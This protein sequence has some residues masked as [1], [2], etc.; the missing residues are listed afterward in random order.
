[1]EKFIERDFVK[2]NKIDYDRIE[3]IFKN[4]DYLLSIWADHCGID[5]SDDRCVYGW[6]DKFEYFYHGY[7]LSK[8][9]DKIFLVVQR[10]ERDEREP[11]FAY[12]K[13]FLDYK[14]AIKYINNIKEIRNV[15]YDIEEIEI[16]DEPRKA[17]QS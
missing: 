2:G 9:Q 7:M 10:D 1:M 16:G 5:K 15:Y 12:L 8:N 6:P 13:Y 17:S 14:A 4:D 3:S 11:Q